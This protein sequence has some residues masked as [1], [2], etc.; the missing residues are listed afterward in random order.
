MNFLAC[1]G[2]WSSGASGIQC[3]G[4]LI[5]ITGQELSSEIASGI[6]PEDSD[7]LY[8]AAVSLFVSVFVFLIL[9][10]VVR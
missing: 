10:R 8:D 5:T 7:A 4:T 9:K 6:T 1:D 3:S 2:E